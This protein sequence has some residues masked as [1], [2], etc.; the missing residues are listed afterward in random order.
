MV[1]EEWLNE[2]ESV[3]SDNIVELWIETSKMFKE[4]KEII[5]NGSND[6]FKEQ[7][8]AIRRITNTRD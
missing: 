2:G 7:V 8:F 1:H 4:I 6:N 5:D 3:Y